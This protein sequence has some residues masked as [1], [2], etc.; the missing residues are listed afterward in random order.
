ML[1][2]GFQC[3]PNM[4][5]PFV[6]GA[7]MQSHHLKIELHCTVAGR[8]ASSKPVCIHK[9]GNLS[10]CR[11]Q[12]VPLF[13]FQSQIRINKCNLFLPD[14]KSKFR[15]TPQ[16]WPRTFWQKVQSLSHMLC[17]LV[18]SRAVSGLGSGLVILC[19]PCISV[20]QTLKKMIGLW[21]WFIL[22]SVSYIPGWPSA[23]CLAM[24]DLKLF[25]PLPPYWDWRCAP[26]QAV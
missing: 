7:K 25:V 21:F 13:C 1:C 2:W 12:E 4:L 10:H 11:G 22:D 14:I 16:D 9:G 17:A 20:T 19:H 24:D 26:P 3:P 18:K 8:W 23:H 6:S 5:C 15:V